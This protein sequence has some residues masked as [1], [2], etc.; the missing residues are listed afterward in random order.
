VRETLVLRVSQSK[1]TSF[2][3]GTWSPI[4]GRGG[5]VGRKTMLIPTI[6]QLIVW[7]AFVCG[8]VGHFQALVEEKTELCRRTMNWS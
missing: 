4:G 2:P 5:E 1:R 3:D 6:A 8:F 7:R